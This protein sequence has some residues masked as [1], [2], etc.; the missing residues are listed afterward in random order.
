[1]K[2]DSCQV[3]CHCARCQLPVYLLLQSKKILNEILFY[4]LISLA[5]LKNKYIYQVVLCL[6]I[7]RKSVAKF[8]L[9]NKEYITIL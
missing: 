9:T 5:Y 2:R 1:M 4:L 6:K 8:G 7:M 3:G